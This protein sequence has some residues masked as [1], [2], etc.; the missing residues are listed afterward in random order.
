MLSSRTAV[1]SSSTLHCKRLPIRARLPTV[2]L[3]FRGSSNMILMLRV[4]W[5]ALAFV[6]AQAV[7]VSV[8]YGFS[9][10]HDPASWPLLVA[11]GVAALVLA[12][13]SL[14][15]QLLRTG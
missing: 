3:L 1:I 6:A 15:P 2:W 14:A 10:S 13:Y 8:T 11:C 12:G 7:T 4:P 5:L 9:L